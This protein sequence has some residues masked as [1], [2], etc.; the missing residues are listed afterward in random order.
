[1]DDAKPF[2]R[3]GAGARAALWLLAVAAR[4]AALLRPEPSEFEAATL[5]EPAAPFASKFLHVGAYAFLTV[6]SLWQLAS[7]RGRAGLVVFLAV[8][9]VATEYLQQFV[10]PRWPSWADVG[11]NF[12]GILAGLAAARILAGGPRRAADLAGPRLGTSQE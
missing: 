3:P 10:P 6:L 8:H 1:M 7:P 12:I 2:P 5:P 11:F 9:A 4:T